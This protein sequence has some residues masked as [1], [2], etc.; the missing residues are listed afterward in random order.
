[1]HALYLFACVLS[2]YAWIDYSQ[3]CLSQQI[4]CV[5]FVSVLFWVIVM[6]SINSH[7]SGDILHLNMPSLDSYQRKL[8][9]IA[10]VLSSMKS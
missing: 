5:L 7:A 3:L 6:T 1:M 10:M 2:P 8:I 4:V 9:P